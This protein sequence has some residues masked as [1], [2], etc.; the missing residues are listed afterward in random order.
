MIYVLGFALIIVTVFAI[1]VTRKCIMLNDKIESLGESVDESLDI[2]D[3]CY[4]DVSTAVS[5]PVM[6]DE[7]VVRNVIAAMRRARESIHVVAT[8]LVEFDEST[9][10]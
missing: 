2:L 7:P 1:W 4:N 3:A 10:V 9:D 8:K 5:T 6:S